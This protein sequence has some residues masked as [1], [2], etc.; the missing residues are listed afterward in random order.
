MP[1]LVAAALVF[2]CSA[3]V[4]VLEILAGR[5]LAPY[6]GISLETYTSIIGTV[7]AGIAAGTWL[8][9]KLA[10]RIDPRRLLGPT[11]AL[12]GLLA[13]FTVPVVRS[14]GDNSAADGSRLTTIWLTVAGFFL[15]AFVLSAVHPMVVKLQL[16][17]LDRTG[18]VVGRLS[19]VATAGALVGTFVTGFLLVSAAPT[20]TIAYAL[21]AVLVAV[22]L[23]CTLWLARRD[24]TIVIAIAVLGAAGVT[25]AAKTT[26]P[27]DVESAYYCIRVE[28]DLTNPSG[29][30][31]WLDDLRHSY[32]DLADPTDLQ[33]TYVRSFAD[34]VAAQF[35]DHPAL[36]ALHI[37][38]GG[39]T[40]PRYLQAEY[41]GTKSTVLE[42]DPE[43]LKVGREKLGL[44]TG[45]DLRVRI[46]DARIGIRAEAD[47]SA[48]LVVSDAFGSLS[49]PWH[50]ATT[51]FMGEV[52][53]VL[54]PDGVYVLN[55]I[56]YP[57]LR[58]ARAE[59][60]TLQDH[61]E[62]VAV[63]A[64]SYVLDGDDGGNL[65]L[66]ASHRALD[67]TAL[68]QSARTTGV[69]LVEGQKVDRLID[70]MPVITDDYAPVD[71]W[72]S[73]DKH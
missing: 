33:F 66:V 1:A 24:S 55:V 19:G 49:V 72:L 4:L 65:V 13:M 6:V 35:P 44:Q 46:G 59:L 73:D 17:D 64:P 57:P 58:F 53:R 12:G 62:H 69:E 7:L 54:R 34:V 10:D 31:L 63:L 52:Q 36:D 60:R 42:I 22:G 28:R 25:I 27:C 5:L 21:G 32:V 2:L 68:Q 30:T 45:P 40:L 41:P 29:R 37:G 18:R 48:D 9:G 23:V 43:V 20:S 15:P 8:G 67:S 71:Q 56:D 61:F 16:H 39:F 51:E 38:G 11:I 26:S 50:L 3:C 70:G 14:L 47:D